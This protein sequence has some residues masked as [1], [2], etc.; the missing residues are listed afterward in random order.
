MNNIKDE[1][2]QFIIEKILSNASILQD[3][4]KE[5]EKTSFD[6]GLLQGY[7]EVIDIIKNQMIIDDLDLKKYGLDRIDKKL[8]S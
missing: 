7:S 1:Q 8:F 6:D 5:R 3:E 4:L 2:M